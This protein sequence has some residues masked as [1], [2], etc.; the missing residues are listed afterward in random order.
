MTQEASSLKGL[1]E[2]YPLNPDEQYCLYFRFTDGW[3]YGYVDSFGCADGVI[4]RILEEPF[5]RGFVGIWI[6]K[7]SGDGVTDV[8][9]YKRE[10]RTLP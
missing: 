5:R 4:D 1:M 10:R 2:L 9:I 7:E 6:T 3:P 8:T